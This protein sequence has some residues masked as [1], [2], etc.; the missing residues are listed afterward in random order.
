VEEKELVQFDQVDVFLKVLLSDE[1][2]PGGLV[3]EGSYEVPDKAS[4][5]DD[6]RRRLAKG[7]ESMRKLTSIVSRTRNAI[8]TLTYF[9]HDVA[10]R[11]SRAVVPHRPSPRSHCS[12]S[13]ESTART[14]PDM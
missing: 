8:C 7:E 5:D 1:F 10:R 4:R 6:G 3:K 11:V 12:S 9:R 2:F 14:G 13:R